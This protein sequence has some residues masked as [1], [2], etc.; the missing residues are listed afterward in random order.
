MAQASGFYHLQSTE[1]LFNQLVALGGSPLIHPLPAGVAEVAFGIVTNALGL[2]KVQPAEQVKA[3]LEIPAA[4]LSAKLSKTPFPLAAVI[5]DDIVKSTPTFARLADTASIEKLFPGIKWCKT[6][7][8]GDSQVDGMIMGITALANR[9]D[10]L[11]SSLKKCLEAVFPDDGPKVTAILNGYG[12]DESKDDKMAVLDFVNDIAFAQGARAAAQAWAGPATR[13][14]SKAYLAHFNIPNPWDGP[15]KGHA[16]HALDV[17]LVLGNYNEFL[18]EGQK[19]CAEKMAADL[20][21]LAHGQEPFPAYSGA[22][23]GKSMVYYAGTG[24]KKDESYV[25]SDSDESKTGRRAILDEV[26]AGNPDVLDK[27]LGVF[28]LFIQGPR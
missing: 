20:L 18:G 4:E 14:G 2:E 28:A 16:T 23:D 25:V 21:S 17:A 6:L 27:L 15:W 13:L 22:Q 3:L 1:P 11:A 10:N 5:D 9:P 26:A 19:A 12:I 24:S 8:I 7:M